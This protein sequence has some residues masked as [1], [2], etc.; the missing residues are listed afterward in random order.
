MGNGVCDYERYAQLL[1]M[2][3]SL[4]SFSS[5]TFYLTAL[6][7]VAATNYIGLIAIL[8]YTQAYSNFY[9]LN[10]SAV[11]SVDQVLK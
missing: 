10:S 6:A 1:K 9:Y 7:S 3:D 8:G 11:M 4:V 5:S 2:S